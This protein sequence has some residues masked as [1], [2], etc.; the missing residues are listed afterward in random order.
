MLGRRDV[1]FSMVRS[2]TCDV[3]YGPG[4]LVG[5][6]G[7]SLSRLDV[8]ERGRRERMGNVCSILDV[9][10]G[11][12]LERVGIVGSNICTLLLYEEMAV[13]V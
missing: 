5:C 1:V 7:G 11:T 10:L 8:M 9:I 3:R 2:A 12:A 4:V 13:I 6:S